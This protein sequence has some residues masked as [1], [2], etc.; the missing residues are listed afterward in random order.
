MI[1]LSTIENQLL[2]STVRIVAKKPDGKTSVGTAFYFTFHN[3]EKSRTLPVLITNKHVV[4]GAITGEFF[5]HLGK[6]QP[7]GQLD[8]T[9]ESATFSLDEFEQR[10]IPHPGDA[11][12]CAMLVKPLLDS[13]SAS[14][15]T[16]FQFSLVEELVPTESELRALSATETVVM[17]GYPVGLW[18][19]T[20]NFPV[21]RRGMTASHP[22][23]DFNGK[24]EAVLD[25]AAF[26]GS[27][28]SPVL[29]LDQTS[30]F[31]DVL[32]RLGKP[33][34]YLLGVLFGGPQIDAQGRIEIVDIPTAMESRI[35]TKVMVHLGYYVKAKE[36]QVLKHHLFSKFGHF[37]GP[38]LK[39]E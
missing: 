21:L 22:Y 39:R 2:Y 5:V 38:A 27:S 24:P 29:I 25:I 26:P 23:F 12:L 14:G 8:A 13:V 34:T 31:S 18:D 35:Q 4:K 17:V 20:N 36:L 32:V 28:G 6:A 11:D 1:D 30:Q 37:P 9:P 19:E 16:L 7:D 33:R 3:P 10:W 15:K